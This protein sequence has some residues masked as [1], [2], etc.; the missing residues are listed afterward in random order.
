V[1]DAVLSF[2]AAIQ[3][4]DQAQV[5]AYRAAFGDRIDELEEFYLANDDGKLLYTLLDLCSTR[6]RLYSATPSPLSV[7]FVCISSLGRR[8]RRP[9]REA[10]PALAKSTSDCTARYIVYVLIEYL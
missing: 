9:L 5:E 8:A 6:A 7:T 2:T 4:G 1:D 10:A 3:R